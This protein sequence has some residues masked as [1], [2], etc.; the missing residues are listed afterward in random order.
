MP[1]F[2]QRDKSG[3]SWWDITKAIYY[4][5][6][7]YRRRYLFLVFLLFIVNLYSL[8]PPLLMGMVVDFFVKYKPGTDLSPFYLYSLVFGVSFIA[9][10][11][12]RLSIKSTMGD[13][14]SEI[15]YQLKVSGF[16]KL[17]EHSVR[18]HDS[19]ET[20]AKVQRIQNGLRLFDDFLRMLRND[21][22]RTVTTFVGI[23]VVFLILK[24]VYVLFFVTYLG[25]F[26]LIMRYFYQKINEI[27]EEYFKSVEKA[28]GTYVEGLSNILT[29]KT[30]GA[31]E[32]FKNHI[33]K[34]EVKTKDFENAARRC[35]NR[36]WKSYQALNGVG[37]AVFLIIV[38]YGVINGS[39]STGYIVIFWGYFQ[40]LIGSAN[41]I[42][43]AYNF[44]LQDKAGIAR[45]MPIFLAK[46]DT[47]EG[48][49]TFPANWNSLRII[50]GN[51]KY[52][53]KAVTD[54]EEQLSNVNLVI[55]KFQKV[56]IVGKTGSGKST[57]AK[58]L[59]GLYGLDS[60]EY[61][62]GDVSFYKIR[63]EQV[64]N[65]IA[66]VLQESEM[67]NM[68]VQDNITL[69]RKLDP[70]LLERAVRIAQLDEVID[71]LPQGMDTLIGEKGYHLS[72]GERQRVG[73]ARAIYKDPQILILD[74]AT[75]S[76]DNKTEE[77]LQKALEAELRQKTVITI[78]HRISTLKNVDVIHVME[79]GEII[80]TGR[81]QDLLADPSSHFAQ[82]SLNA[83]VRA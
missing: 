78:A 81:Y 4:L 29:I 71:K 11:Y 23:I 75:S 61:Q 41:D 66:L 79:N 73:V 26:I 22:M 14:Q 70:Q 55:S 39:T 17:L 20:G 24:P 6:G 33:A 65:E 32:G 82:I 56:G 58:I 34:N 50:N 15:R 54:N 47:K 46:S 49:L 59:I 36:M 21:L 18:W 44:L 43:D 40:N 38:G 31:H 25:I 68:S 28:G 16:E 19:E 7:N 57:L 63:R 51:F 35:N 83:Q 5:F 1:L 27:N 80:E 53:V 67:F 72:G 45:M 10:S 37:I 13:Y 30:L 9:I 48:K 76:L 42:L 74:E 69:M 3:M 60:G 2:Y 64:T 77:A 62:I 8:V 12:I 52:R